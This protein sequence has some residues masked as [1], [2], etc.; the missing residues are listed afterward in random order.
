MS[1]SAAKPSLYFPH[2]N[3]LRAFAAL[4]VVVYHVKE[5]LPWADFPQKPEMLLWFHAG[6][7]GVDLFFVLSG[8]VIALSAFQLYGRSTNLAEARGAFLQRRLARIIPL[9][10]LTM[11]LFLG[12][13]LVL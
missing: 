2:L 10:L 8:F 13:R 12:A 6:W 11:L 4:S 7:M 1:E 9:Y 5:L 3:L